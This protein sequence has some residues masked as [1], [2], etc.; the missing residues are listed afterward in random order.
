MK[1]INEFPKG[2][3]MLGNHSLLYSVFR[4]LLENAIFYSKGTRVTVR[5][6]G[7]NEWEYRISVEDDGVGVDS[8]HLARIFERFYRVDKGRSRKIGGTGL[9]LSIV[10]NAVNLHGGSI[11]AVPVSPSG[12]RFELTLAKES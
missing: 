2:K 8:M 12:L 6:D 9:G 3:M 4:N 11:K 1:I 10:K 5:L 7:E